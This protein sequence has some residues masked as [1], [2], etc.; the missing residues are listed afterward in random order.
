MSSAEP[1]TERTEPDVRAPDGRDGRAP[2]PGTVPVVAPAAA[3]CPASPTTSAFRA[4][5]GCAVTYRP[6][7][8]ASAA[9]TV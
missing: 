4:G 9:S 1:T 3:P 2:A 5:V 8:V 7:S 6:A